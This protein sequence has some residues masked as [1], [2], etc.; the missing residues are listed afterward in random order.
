MGL[1][2]LDRSQVDPMFFVFSYLAPPFQNLVSE[3]TIKG[4]TVDRIALK[5]FPSF[6]MK[7]PN[8]DVQARVVEDVKNTKLKIADLEAA[9]QSKLAAL[10]ELKQSLLQKAFAGELT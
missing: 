10:S 8:I 4:A 5:D 7:I 3:Q 9:Y 1:V 2:R 6:Q